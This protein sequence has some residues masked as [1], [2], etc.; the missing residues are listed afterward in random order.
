MKSLLKAY[1]D[2]FSPNDPE[3]VAKTLTRISEQDTWNDVFST[4]L[5]ASSGEFVGVFGDSARRLAEEPVKF[6][7]GGI[8][9]ILLRLGAAAMDQR[10]TFVIDHIAENLADVFPS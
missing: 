9:G 1:G 10:T 8:E 2:L 3:L 6:S 4:K 7:A 5:I